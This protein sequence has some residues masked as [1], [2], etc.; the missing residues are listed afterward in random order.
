MATS[1]V[2]IC[3]LGLSLLGDKT[4]TSLD[5]GTRPANLCSTHYAS[6]RDKVLADYPWTFAL[7][8]AQL[9][10]LV[11]APTFEWTYSYQLPPDCLRPLRTNFDDLSDASRWVVEGRQL[12][13]NE[14][15][16]YLA[17]ISRVT[18][19]TQYSPHFVECLA[20]YIAHLVAYALTNSRQT[21]TELLQTYQYRLSEAE[22]VDGQIGNGY[23]PTIIV[24]TLTNARR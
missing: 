4:I 24:S 18:D 10:Q 17:Y 6:A 2:Q 7:K 23:M 14:A 11:M 16:V 20:T 5:D 12:L 9:A 21:R 1:D 22:E 3:N 13:T 19:P 15:E 8:R